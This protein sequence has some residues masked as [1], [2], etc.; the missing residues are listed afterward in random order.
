MEGVGY[1]GEMEG[2]GG[3]AA[4]KKSLSTPALF[5][6]LSPPTGRGRGLGGGALHTYDEIEQEG[7]DSEDDD[8]FQGMVH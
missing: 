7:S 1:P 4:L 2:S 8:D 5:S 6:I 3:F